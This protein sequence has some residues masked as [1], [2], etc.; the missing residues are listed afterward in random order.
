[1]TSQE[2]IGT[3]DVFSELPRNHF[4]TIYADPPWHFQSWT[5]GRW[6]GDG[7]V[8][9]PAKA[10]E[11]HT[12]SVDQIAALPVAS[13]AAKDCVLLMWGIWSTLPEAL[14]VADAWG[15]KYKSCAF[16][17]MKADVTQIDMFRDSAETQLGLG[18]WTRQDSEYCL[19]ATRG[20][21]KKKSSN[22]H[23]GIIERRR[24]HSRKPD[25]AYSRIEQ[26]VDGPYLELFARS[27]RPGWT[28]WGAEVGKFGMVTEAAP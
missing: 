22:V 14:R 25:C 8:F 21:P 1:M 11:Y 18:Y 5:N 13:L 7:K 3:S 2:Q 24:Q 16:N 12:M 17:W 10:P 26:L 28:A 15:F 4:R 23:Q 20:S 19:L 9:T 6:K 27:T